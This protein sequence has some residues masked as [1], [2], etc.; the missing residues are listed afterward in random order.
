VKGRYI[1]TSNHAL[2]IGVVFITI[3]A[4]KTAWTRR[5]SSESKVSILQHFGLPEAK[6][7]LDGVLQDVNITLLYQVPRVNPGIRKRVLVSK[8]DLTYALWMNQRR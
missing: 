5:Q 7:E 6:K 3:F 4:E 8:T 1:I 2:P